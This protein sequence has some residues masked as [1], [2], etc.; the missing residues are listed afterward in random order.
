MA[1]RF[2]CHTWG[3]ACSPAELQGQETQ[4]ILAVFRRDIHHPDQKIFQTKKNFLT[5]FFFRQNF[6][7]TKIFF[8]DKNFFLDKIFFFVRKF[9]YGP[10]LIF[11]TKIFFHLGW[12]YI[13]ELSH[14]TKSHPPS[15]PGSGLKVWLVG[16]GWWVVVVVVCKASLVFSLVPS[17][18]KMWEY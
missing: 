14:H 3:L 12:P 5:K 13:C 10:K 9:F 18:T 1:S 16:G 7:H 17:C 2:M 4:S 11:W 6:F 15:M 8:S